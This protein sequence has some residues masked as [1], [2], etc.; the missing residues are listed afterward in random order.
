MGS[1]VDVDE[2]METTKLLR[3][4]LA[5]LGHEFAVR[6]HDWML[7]AVGKNQGTWVLKLRFWLE[8]F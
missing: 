7:S 5:V 2:K 4:E 3:N 8:A 6:G 1:N